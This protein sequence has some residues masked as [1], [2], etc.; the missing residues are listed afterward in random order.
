MVGLHLG[1][2][3]DDETQTTQTLLWASRLWARWK[4]SSEASDLRPSPVISVASG[5]SSEKW[6]LLRPFT[7][8]C[9][10]GT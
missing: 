4:L 5:S 9:G 3:I 2:R 6:G 1:V 10:G 8:W 7:T